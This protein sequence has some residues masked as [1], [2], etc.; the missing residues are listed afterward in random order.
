MVKNWGGDVDESGEVYVVILCLPLLIPIAGIRFFLLFYHVRYVE[1]F[2]WGL[3]AFQAHTLTVTTYEW[4]RKGEAY[5]VQQLA[6]SM[7]VRCVV[8]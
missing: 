1:L 4:H 8:R 6:G 5:I 3:R 2:G 7:V